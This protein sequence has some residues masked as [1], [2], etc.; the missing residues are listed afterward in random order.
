MKH[1]ILF[2]LVLVSSHLIVSAEADE[3][4]KIDRYALVNRHNVSLEKFDSLS[5]LSVG[6][7][8]FTF[9]ADLTGLQSFPSLYLSGIA[10]T[11][12][13]CWQGLKAG[14]LRRK[15]QIRQIQRNKSIQNNYSCRWRLLNLSG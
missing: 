3:D 13:V 10:I 14:F 6:N 4:T 5:P 12:F 8:K 1:K 9:T 15:K 2:T 11:L 7:G